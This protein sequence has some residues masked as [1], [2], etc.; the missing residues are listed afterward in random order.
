MIETESILEMASGL[1]KEQVNSETEKIIDNILDINTEAKKKRTLTLTIDFLPN[2]DR[3]EVSVTAT[4]KSKLLPSN[5]VQT[6]LYVGADSFT[7][8]LQAV[9]M[10]PQIPGQEDFNGN[11]QNEPKSLKIT[12]SLKNTEEA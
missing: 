10:T 5:S 9:E 11:I 12:R 1:I 2:W 4:A 6:M 8:E 3:S 7:G